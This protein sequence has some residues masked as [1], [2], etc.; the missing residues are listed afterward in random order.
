MTLDD[1]IEWKAFIIWVDMLLSTRVES[2]LRV[3]GVLNVAGQEYS[4]AIHVV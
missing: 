3:K 1:P 2:L 4:V